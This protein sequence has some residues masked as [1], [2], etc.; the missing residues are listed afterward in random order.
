MP[1]SVVR[2]ENRVD[3]MIGGRRRKDRRTTPKG[4]NVDAQAITISSKWLRLK[5]GANTPVNPL[6]FPTE[7]G[8]RPPRPFDSAQAGSQGRSPVQSRGAAGVR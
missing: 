8:G 2:E 7:E 1:K 5:R 4:P 6:R 3:G